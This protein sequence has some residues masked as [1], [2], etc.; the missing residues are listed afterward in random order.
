MLNFNNFSY[1]DNK[2][3]GGPEICE[4]S[5]VLILYKLALSEKDLYGGNY[6]ESTY[7]PDIPILIKVNRETLLEGIYKGLIG[8]HGG[9]SVRSIVIPPE[10]GYGKLGFGPIP[11]NA[12]LFAEVCV[13]AVNT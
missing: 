9:G 3:S 2:I 1:T 13:V 6:L 5:M 10:M 12:T 7:S 4:D 8:M 11:P